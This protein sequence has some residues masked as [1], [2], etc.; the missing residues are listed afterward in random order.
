MDREVK[1]RLRTVMSVLNIS[2]NEIAY[3]T[4]YTP[5]MVSKSLNPKYDVLTIKFLNSVM[6]SFPDVKKDYRQWIVEGSGKSPLISNQT[7]SG[8]FTGDNEVENLR[9]ENEVLFKENGV[10]SGQ[11]SAMRKE[12][13]RVW[14]MLEKAMQIHPDLSAKLLSPLAQN[15]S[16]V[17]VDVPL[18]GRLINSLGAKQGALVH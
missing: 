8:L 9:K 16:M 15:D 13:D 5:N 18:T 11:V 12:L 4:G 6:D 3:K 1:T 14:S 7:L 2:N 17:L 10:L